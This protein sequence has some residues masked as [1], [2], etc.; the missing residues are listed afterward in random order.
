MSNRYCMLSA[1]CFPLALGPY[2]LRFERAFFV[3]MENLGHMPIYPTDFYLSTRFTQ[4][5]GCSTNKITTRG[6]GV[7]A[8]LASP[9]Y[10]FSTAF[11]I[12]FDPIAPSCVLLNSFLH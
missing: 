12:I 5:V 3:F 6:L 8:S 11:D 2:N 10:I 4:S 7:G 9:F 1:T